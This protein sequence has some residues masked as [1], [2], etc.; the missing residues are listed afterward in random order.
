[1]SPH[2][3]SFHPEGPS[4]FPQGWD[5]PRR[6]AGH[7]TWRCFSPVTRRCQQ[8]AVECLQLVTSPEPPRPRSIVSGITGI[9]PTSCLETSY[10]K[11]L[12]SLLQQAFFPP[13]SADHPERKAAIC[14]EP[15]GPGWIASPLSHRALDGHQ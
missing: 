3:L 2:H 12:H 4:A 11:S 14:W 1:M 9:F 7:P 10:P 5:C 8:R 15:C 6:R 13:M